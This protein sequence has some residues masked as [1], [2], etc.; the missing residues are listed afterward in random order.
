VSG[1]SPLSQSCVNI[2]FTHF[3][4]LEI[5]RFFLDTF[6]QVQTVSIL[7]SYILGCSKF[8][9]NAW[10]HLSESEL[11]Q[12]T[13]S[14]ILA[15]Q[16]LLYNVR[17]NLNQ[18]I[19]DSNTLALPKWLYTIWT[20]YPRG[21]T[22]PCYALVVLVSSTSRSFPLLPSAPSC[23]GARVVVSWAWS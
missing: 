20:Y 9:Y 15:W 3:G 23:S 10:T 6:L 5:M 7:H 19:P 18:T 22:N 21:F 16:T 11:R 4:W 12:I 2:Q 8:F 14:H 1:H 13:H 17:L